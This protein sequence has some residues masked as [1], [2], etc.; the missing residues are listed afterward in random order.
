[1]ATQLIQDII[2]KCV[3]IEVQTEFVKTLAGKAKDPNWVVV[4][5]NYDFLKTMAKTASG[6]VVTLA[7]ELEALIP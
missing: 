3:A 4:D 6:L 2:D 1:M 5:P 7:Q